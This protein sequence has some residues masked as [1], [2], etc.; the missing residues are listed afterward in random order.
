MGG[1]FL[2][3]TAENIPSA[4]IRNTVYNLPTLAYR[5]RKYELIIV[6]EMVTDVLGILVQEFYS[7]SSSNKRAGQWK[8]RTPRCKNRFL[9]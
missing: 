7:I 1:N 6:Y 8:I 3:T 9:Y 4:N 5:R 2:F